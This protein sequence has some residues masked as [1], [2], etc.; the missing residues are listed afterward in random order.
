MEMTLSRENNNLGVPARCVYPTR[1]EA[2]GLLDSKVKCGDIGVQF[3]EKDEK[4]SDVSFFRNTDEFYG[5]DFSQAPVAGYTPLEL[6]TNLPEQQ[7]AR[8]LQEAE[9]KAAG[10][11]LTIFAKNNL[12]WVQRGDKDYD[13]WLDDATLHGSAVAEI[14]G[15]N[16]IINDFS[17]NID[18]QK[19]LQELEDLLVSYSQKGLNPA[20]YF[21]VIN[22]LDESFPNFEVPEHIKAKAPQAF[23]AA[24]ATER[25]VIIFNERTISGGLNMEV[26]DGFTVGRTWQDTFNHELGHFLDMGLAGHNYKSDL[27]TSLGWHKRVDVGVDDYGNLF[28]TGVEAGRDYGLSVVDDYGLSTKVYN[29]KLPDILLADGKMDIN[30]G[31]VKP[32]SLYAH[33]NSAEDI[34]ESFAAHMAFGGVKKHLDSRRTS[35]MEQLIQEKSNMEA[36]LEGVRVHEVAVEDFDPLDYISKTIK[37]KA[38]ITRIPG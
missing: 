11:A 22:I 4:G 35:A 9:S 25:G 31:E 24:Q 36:S 3:I 8:F 37:V 30:G 20:E 14:G 12:W 26:D 6:S 38:V 5:Y 27:A 33:E 15:K 16:I 7:Q 17:G 13:A 32:P 10:A 28:E 1:V 21:Q 19:F 23:K 2:L 18:R 34:A 29:A